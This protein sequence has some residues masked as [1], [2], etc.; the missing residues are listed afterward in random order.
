[1]IFF[2]SGLLALAAIY[3]SA[4]G[5]L[6]F[7][8]ERLLHHSVALRNAA[9]QAQFHCVE[10]AGHGDVHQFPSFRKAVASALGCL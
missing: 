9:P 5:W 6:W 8:Q 1:M 2:L 4:I 10:G 7:W 3:A